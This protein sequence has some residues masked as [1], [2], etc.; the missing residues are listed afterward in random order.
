MVTLFRNNYYPFGLQFNS[1]ARSTNKENKFLYNGVEK[2]EDLGFDMYSTLFILYDPAIGRF[3][4]VDPLA[5]F[6]TGINP[7]NFGFNNPISFADPAGLAPMWWI[8]LK[9]QGNKLRKRLS[10]DKTSPGEAWGKH[11][12][13]R[14]Y[15]KTKNHRIGRSRP[16]KPGGN[17]EIKR[18]D[19]RPTYG[20]PQLTSGYKP[21][22][23]DPVDIIYPQK[24]TPYKSTPPR[25]GIAG[26]TYVSDFDPFEL[27]KNTYKKGKED[28][29][30]NFLRPYVNDLNNFPNSHIEIMVGISAGGK[31]RRL[32]DDTGSSA[33][34]STELV[35]MRGGAIRRA[36]RKLGLKNHD[37]VKIKGTHKSKHITIDVIK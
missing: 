20:D 11:K 31:P 13:N 24:K 9:A 2:V 6:M 28:D 32:P 17:I 37:Q 27:Y 19:D 7:Y 12:G 3:H 29:V 21:E 35:N 4:Q 34:T 16:P 33:L 10:G 26:Q 36:L 8:K 22:M 14:V 23:E 30:L 15:W 5:D 1:W 18:I 25:K